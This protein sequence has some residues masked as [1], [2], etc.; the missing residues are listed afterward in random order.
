ML[1]VRRH[2]DPSSFLD[3]AEPW[4]CSNEAE[5]N[6]LLAV[7]YLLAPDGGHFRPPFY[8]ATVEDRQGVC[9]CAV[10]PPP[11][12]LYLTPMPLAAVA[13]IAEQLADSHARIPEVIGPEEVATEFARCWQP[14]RWR[15]HSR[16]W[17]YSLERVLPPRKRAPGVLRRAAPRD[18]D[19]LGEWALVYARE[20]GTKVDVG[21]FFR[22]MV[23]RRSMYLWDDR[24][25]RCA[26]TVSG[27]TKNGARI[28]SVYTPADFRRR[29][30]AENAV[31]AVCR[32]ILNE[33]RRF[34]VITADVDSPGPNVIYRRLGF[35]RHE[36]FA[37]IHFS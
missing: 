2:S 28:S 31:A 37:E 34:C 25:P 10:C 27:L 4:L 3:R 9:G 35:E 22:R 36:A 20:V 29:G 8:L 5:H 24:G 26:V 23:E 21:A 16:L 15:L 33:G 14:Q 30:Y 19:F 6:I 1:H 18:M 13:S 7:A 11:D 12:G 17:R 32:L